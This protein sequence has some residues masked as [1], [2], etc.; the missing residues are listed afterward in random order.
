MLCVPHRVGHGSGCSGPGPRVQRRQE[1]AARGGHSHLHWLGLSPCLALPGDP[2]QVSCPW[3][4]PLRA[5]M[6]L[7]KNT[8]Q[9]PSRGRERQ[10]LIQFKKFFQLFDRLT[11]PRARSCCRN[12]LPGS[13]GRAKANGRA[14]RPG[15]PRMSPALCQQLLAMARVWHRRV[16]QRWLERGDTVPGRGTAHTAHCPVRPS[17]RHPSVLPSSVPLPGTCTLERKALAGRRK[18]S[19]H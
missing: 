8:T 1:A 11:S 4:A 18:L 10:E 2:G 19:S 6:Y 12:A 17:S 16:P 14:G 15:A 3:G 7:V 13:A 5:V 9:P